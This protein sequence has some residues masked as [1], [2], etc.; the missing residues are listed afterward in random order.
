MQKAVPY[1]ISGYVKL[2]LENEVKLALLQMKVPILMVYPVYQ[3][4]M[5]TGSDGIVKVPDYA[6]EKFYGLHCIIQ[7][8][9][10]VRDGIKYR[11]N[12]NSWD[13]TWGLNGCCLIPEELEFREAWLPIDNQFPVQNFNVVRIGGTDRFETASMV[14]NKTFDYAENAVLVN[15]Y[16]FPDALSG[17]VLAYQLNAPILLTDK[18]YI[19]DTILNTLNTLNVKNVYIIGGTGAVSEFVEATLYKKYNTIRIA[20]NDRY[21]TAIKVAN[22]IRENNKFDTCVIAT[23]NDYPDALSIAPFASRNGYPIIYAET[24]NLKDVLA[25]WGI[26]KVVIAGGYGVVSEFLGI[27]I[28]YY[29]DYQHVEKEDSRKVLRLSG[30][31]RYQTSLEIARY[32]GEFEDFSNVVIATGT[33]FADAL[34][35]S[36]MAAKF[37]APMLLVDKDTV[38]EDILGYISTNEIKN[39]FVLGG[40]GVISDKVVNL[41]LGK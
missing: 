39:V 1:K 19:P 34:V 31:D 25:N 22:K 15:G 11:I 24:P 2:N 8:G 32:F 16:N 5:E 29:W 26:K 23:G 18:D 17:S 38:D 28:K 36:I 7:R 12:Q 27:D 41:I 6:N 40:S 14:C 3:S 35:G 21:E 30:Y 10:T 13:E 4:F 33:N 37:N 9:F 20:G